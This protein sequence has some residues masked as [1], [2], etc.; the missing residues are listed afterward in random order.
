MS[1]PTKG[2]APAASELSSASTSP[3]P[4]IPVRSP[5]VWAKQKS[6]DPALVAGAAVLARWPAGNLRYGSLLVSEDDFDAAIKAFRGL[7]IR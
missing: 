2:A 5:S 7:E 3:P 4:L 6:V 1:E